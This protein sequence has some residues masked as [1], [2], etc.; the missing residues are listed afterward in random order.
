MFAFAPQ[1]GKAGITAEEPHL[2]EETMKYIILASASVLAI[3]AAPASAQ[4]T[5]KAGVSSV[6]SN[7]DGGIEEIIVTAQRRQESAQKA[8]IAIAVVAVVFVGESSSDNEIRHNVDLF[9]ASVTSGILLCHL[10]HRYWILTG[11]TSTSVE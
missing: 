9:H 1:F 2:G 8:A 4:S 10:N 3:M 7:N 5:P 6:V 11:R